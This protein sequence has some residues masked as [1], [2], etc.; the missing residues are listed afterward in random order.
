MFLE[1]ASSNNKHQKL[2]LNGA[3]YLIDKGANF[4][5]KDAILQKSPYEVAVEKGFSDL[6]QQM[7]LIMAEIC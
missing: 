3:S 2:Y 4:Q 1:N 6:V 5:E 7:D